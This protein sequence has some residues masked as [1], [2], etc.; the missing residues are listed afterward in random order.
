M[1]KREV[2]WLKIISR[3]SRSLSFNKYGIE[4]TGSVELICHAYLK[5]Y[6]LA[7]RPASRQLLKCSHG[8]YH[9]PSKFFR[10]ARQS[11]S[12]RLEGPR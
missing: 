4:T 6:E 8:E 10:C 9:L 11:H 12:L 5:C 3:I 7:T 1:I 2:K